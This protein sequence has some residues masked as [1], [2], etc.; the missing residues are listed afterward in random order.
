MSDITNNCAV[1]SVSDITNNRAVGSVSDITN[2]NEKSPGRCFS[3]Q[4]KSL[5]NIHVQYVF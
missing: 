3:S 1:G 4:G 2:K 5:R